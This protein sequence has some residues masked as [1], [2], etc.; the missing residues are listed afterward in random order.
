MSVDL[1]IEYARTLESADPVP[2]LRDEFLI[3]PHG[4]GERVYLCGNS[5]GLQPRQVAADMQAEL[6]DWA[7]LGVDGHFEAERPWYSYHEAL[8]EP[9]ARIAGAHPHEVVATGTL[10]ANLHALM[11]SFYRPTKQRYRIVIE[12]GAFPSDIYAVTSQAAMHGYGPEAIVELSSPSG[13]RLTAEEI[14]DFFAR[15]G[16]SVAMVLFGGV[17]YY[18]GELFDLAHLTRA[19]QSAGALVGVDLAHAMGNAPLTLHS[20]GVDFAAWCSYKYLNAGPG[21]IAGLYVHERHHHRDTLRMAGWWGTD[22]A[23]RFKMSHEFVPHASAGAWQVSNAPVFS[24]LPLYASLDLFDRIGT[25]ALRARSLRLH[26]YLRTLLMA[27]D[28]RLRFLT[29][30]A[31]EYHGCQLS[32]DAGDAAATVQRRLQTAGVVTDFRPPS[33]I[34]VAPV[35]LYNT[36]VDVWRFASHFSTDDTQ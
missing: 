14:S 28:D 9:L 33:V 25:A 11:V 18:S 26:R 16:E 36:Y 2:S 1:S 6:R 15:E 21:A 5:L 23:T 19:A 32:I 24:M 31:D 8:S 34:R 12:G 27:F 30:D 7:A 4:G 3:P 35:P 13:G 29:P 20:W 22:P 10:T 17:N